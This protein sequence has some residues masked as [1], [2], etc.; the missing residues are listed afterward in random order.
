MIPK[1]KGVVDSALP[2]VQEAWVP[3][4]SSLKAE[5]AKFRSFSLSMVRKVVG[6][7]GPT[8]DKCDPAEK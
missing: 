8:H 7:I 3:F 4:P 5:C 1:G 2:V 6:K